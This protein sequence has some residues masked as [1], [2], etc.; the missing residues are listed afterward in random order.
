VPQKALDKLPCLKSP[1]IGASRVILC[2][3][4]I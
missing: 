4:C 2:L 3:L 1:P